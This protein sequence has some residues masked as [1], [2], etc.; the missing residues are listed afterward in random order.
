MVMDG[1][2]VL[3]CSLNL[4]AKFLADSP[5]Y[6]SSQ[7]TLLA[8][9]SIYD[10]T[11]FPDYTLSFGDIRTSPHQP[12]LWKRFVDDTFII[13]KKAH[14]DSLLQHLNSID[15]N[16]KFTCEESRD[17]GSKPFLDILIIPGREGKLDTTVYRK[18]TPYRLISAMG[19]PSQY[20]SKIQCN[21]YLTSQG[22]NHMLFTST[23]TKRGTTSN[24]S[25]EEM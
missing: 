10:P 3:R 15:N 20:P 14:K 6:S 22:Q 2:G 5:M 19:Q 25:L 17:D 11:L 4:S 23:S 24:L 18:P 12:S 13:I 7:S 8:F 16:I 21:R 1:E 9:V